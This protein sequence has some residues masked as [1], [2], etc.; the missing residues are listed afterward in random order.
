MLINFKAK[1]EESLL[2]NLE[3]SIAVG[4]VAAVTI[5]VINKYF[6]KSISDNK[7]IIS[8]YDYVKAKVLKKTIKDKSDITLAEIPYPK[9]AEMRHTLL[10]GTTGAGKTNAIIELIDQVKAKGERLIIVDTVGTFVEKYYQDGDIILNPL[11]SRSVSWSFLSECNNEILLKNIAACLIGRSDIH[12]KFWEDAAQIVFVETAKKV[13]RENKSTQEFIDLLLKVSLEE[14]QMYLKGT[15]GYSLMDKRADK[16]AISIRATLINAVS[17]FD[18]LKESKSDNFSIRDWVLTTHAITL[19]DSTSALKTH[20]AYPSEDGEAINASAAST[21]MFLSCKPAER[22]ALTPLI[23]AWL[24]IA[25]EAL[26]QTNPTD[27]RTWFFIDELHN[28]KRLPKI[29]TSL[30]EV[31]KFGGCFVIGTQMVSQLNAIYGH[32]TAHTITGLCGTKVVMN[33][34]EPE[35]AKYMS[36]FL[37]EKE[38]ISTMESISYGANTVRDGVNIAQQTHKKSSVPFN[39]IM[40]LKTGEAFIK[41]AGIDLVTKTKFKLVSAT[42]AFTHADST[43]TSQTHLAYLSEGSKAESASGATTS[44]N[45]LLFYGIPLNDE[46]T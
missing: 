33:V 39:E 35:T 12:D 41:F 25:S 42:W 27:K 38:E 46:I 15:Y 30:A 24:S 22:T 20:P 29:E 3:L 10:T 16:M 34:P 4:V 9:F 32:E 1:F 37:G 23:T 8:G 40:N 18:I 14:I 5:L 17:V 13:I 43:S 21:T 44:E 31:R 6:G 19:A 36:G 45:D 11:D 28:L 26:L 7:E 2:L